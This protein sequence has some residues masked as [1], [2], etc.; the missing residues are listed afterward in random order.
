MSG[1]GVI[2]E[3]TVRERHGVHRSLGAHGEFH[4][5][6]QCGATLQRLR[7]AAAMWIS[8]KMEVFF[9]ADAARVRV[10]LCRDC[11]IAVGL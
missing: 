10:W 8:S 4:R 2:V 3:Y 5:G 6:E 11:A 1:Q 7:T 9:W